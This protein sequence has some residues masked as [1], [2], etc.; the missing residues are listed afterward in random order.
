M[1]TIDGQSMVVRVPEDR[2]ASAAPVPE[3][4]DIES[5]GKGRRGAGTVLVVAG[6]GFPGSA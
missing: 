6:V 2:A 5:V 3:L 1:E 4:E